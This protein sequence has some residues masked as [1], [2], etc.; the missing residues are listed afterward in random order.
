MLTLI[1]DTLTS[2]VV[3]L[4]RVFSHLWVKADTVE[5]PDEQPYMFPRWRGRIIL[6]RDPDGEE[7]CVACNLCAVACPVDCIALQKTEDEEGRWYQNFSA[8]IF[9]GALCVVSAK[10]PAQRMPFS[11][12][13]I[14]RWRNTSDK[15]WCGR[16]KTY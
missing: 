5:Y 12:L 11:L 2:Q 1:K 14:S 16:R 10:K 4:W 8:L 13:P 6:S 7:R 15:T 9:L 3:T